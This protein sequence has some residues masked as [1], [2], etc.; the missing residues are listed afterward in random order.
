MENPVGFTVLSIVAR[1]DEAAV[2]VMHKWGMIVAVA[3]VLVVLTLRMCMM[4]AAA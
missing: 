1:P 4:P 2:A 3:S